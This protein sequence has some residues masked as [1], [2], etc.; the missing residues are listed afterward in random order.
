MADTHE[1]VNDKPTRRSRSADSGRST[2]KRPGPIARLS[3]WPPWVSALAA[4][5]G[6]ILTAIGVFNLVGHPAP[7]T[8]A[9]PKVTLESVLVAEEQVAGRGTFEDLDPNVNEVVFVGRPPAATTENWLAVEA[10]LTP[11]AQAGALQDGRWQ[12]VRPAPPPAGYRWYAILW[13]VAAGASGAEDLRLNGPASE[14]VVA[15]SDPFDTP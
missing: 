15:K 7:A 13:P 6:T 5:A 1:T 8:P 11:T 4:M 14:L 3:G 12:A 10:A 9:T 2:A